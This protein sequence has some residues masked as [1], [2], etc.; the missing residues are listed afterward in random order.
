MQK[1]QRK[2][3]EKMADLFMGAHF[4]AYLLTVAMFIV[5]LPR[6]YSYTD[7][8]AVLLGFFVPVTIF[9]A[10]DYYLFNNKLQDPAQKNVLLFWNILKLCVLFLLVTF[11]LASAPY[12]V[13]LQGALYLLPVVLAAISLGRAGGVPFA[14]AA[15]GII[16]FLYKGEAGCNVAAALENVFWLPG[17]FLLAAWYLGSVM[18]IE[19]EV[20]Q[21]LAVL[22]NTDEITGLNNLHF[23]L[24]RLKTGVAAAVKNREPLSLILL[25]INNFK[26]YNEI[27]GHF[28]GDFM[29]KKLAILLQQDI[30]PEAEIARFGGDEF[31]IILP[32]FSLEEAANIA[33]RLQNTVTGLG[34]LGE[35]GL[36]DE[37]TVSAGVA[38]LP[39]HASDY[40]TLLFAAD[41]A[42]YSSKVTGSSKVQVY[43][44][45]LEKI[46]QLVAADEKEMVNSLSVFMTLINVRDRYTYGHSERVAY[47]IKEFASYL[48]MEEKLIRLLEYG[49]FLHDIGKLETPREILN[50]K[51]A[52]TTEEWA[53]LRRHPQWG[54]EM[55]RPI[56]LLAPVIPMVLYHHE[57][58][59]G[60]GYP[61]GL[62]GEDISYF[63]RML[64]IVDSF[65]AMQ[66][67]RPY[68]Q[69]LPR[70]EILLE[71][72]K[73]SGK[74]YD[75]QLVS[76]F[77][78]MSRQKNKP[79]TQHLIYL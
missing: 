73:G 23:F 62:R 17:V 42:L 74:E 4:V 18:E 70:E 11:V 39:M 6:S 32:G 77:V 26:K 55:L 24:E 56:E 21:Q 37:L 8:V 15:S 65:D 36:S 72:E 75:P 61:E 68:H 22:A 41:E 40:R 9:I 44:G 53:V 47:Y 31:S 71:L 63:A 20:N 45:I 1:W 14:L 51:G 69:P 12:T 67:F 3:N 27:H 64:R 49:S 5:C 54:A 60:T 48:G 57:N 43:L 50:K 33:G 25:D 29:L 2:R 76:S 46:R 30:P 7:F 58:Y 38:N 19:N 78:A 52:L 59:D 34:S 28:C 66:T 13:Q 35:M 16:I 79:N 10:L